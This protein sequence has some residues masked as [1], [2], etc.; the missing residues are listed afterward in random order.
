MKNFWGV[1]VG[2]AGGFLKKLKQMSDSLER[3][4]S[5]I[6]VLEG[7]MKEIRDEVHECSRLLEAIIRAKDV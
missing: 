6:K 1:I 2:F 4:E 7:D 5:D 3:A